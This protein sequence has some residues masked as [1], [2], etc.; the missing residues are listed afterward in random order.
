MKTKITV[1]LAILL[2]GTAMAQ[3]RKDR[4]NRKGDRTEISAEQVATR[5]CQDSCCLMFN[6]KPIAQRGT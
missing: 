3:D 6:A 5:C 1:M 2:M 4:P